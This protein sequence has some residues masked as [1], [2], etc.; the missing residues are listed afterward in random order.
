MYYLYFIF[1]FLFSFLTYSAEEDVQKYVINEN[2]EFQYTK[3]KVFDFVNQIPETYIEGFKQITTKESLPWWAAIVISTGVLIHYDEDLIKWSKRV[4]K[5]YGIESVDLTKDLITIRDISFR[6][7]TDVSSAM[8]FIGDGWTHFF[9]LGS[10]LTTGL[11]RND[12]RAIQ[13][14]SQLLQGLINVAISVQFFKRTTGRETPLSAEQPRGKWRFFPNQKKYATN[15]ANYDSFPSGH[16]ATA[17]M[18]FTVIT[19]NYPE[20]SLILKPVGYTLMTLLSYQMM[21]NGVHWA[22][23]Y[24]LALGIGYLF[25]KIVSGKNK[26]VIDKNEN[27]KDKAARATLSCVPIITENLRGIGLQLEF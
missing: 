20:Y 8:Y 18:T 2:I 27:K 6:G 3:P 14:G 21:N 19:E 22:S 9:I 4:G 13:V 7:P 12:N 16:L 15:T 17:M 26:L 5:D 24:P 23:D 10:F 25:G 1:I 11:I